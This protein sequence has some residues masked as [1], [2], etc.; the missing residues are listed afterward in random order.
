MH[1]LKESNPE[2]HSIRLLKGKRVLGVILLHEAASIYTTTPPPRTANKARKRKKPQRQATLFRQA[3]QHG[4]YYPPRP[5]RSRLPRQ[6]QH[7]PEVVPLSCLAH[8]NVGPWRSPSFL[9]RRH[10]RKEQEGEAEPGTKLPHQTRTLSG[11]G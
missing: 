10:T 11:I 9:V 3:Q 6:E 5:R 8:K 4:R 7:D 1:L 2:S